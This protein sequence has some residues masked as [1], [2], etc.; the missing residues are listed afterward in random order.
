MSIFHRHSCS[1]ASK[2]DWDSIHAKV[3]KR[4]KARNPR[5]NVEDVMSAV[6]W[7]VATTHRLVEDGLQIDYLEKYVLVVASRTLSKDCKRSPERNFEF[8]EIE[9]E[10]LSGPFNATPEE[11]LVLRELHE[12]LA[13]A[14]ME[15]PKKLR[16]PLIARFLVGMSYAEMEKA[17]GVPEGTLRN[18]VY[19]GRKK[20]QAEIE[21]HGF[22][23][24]R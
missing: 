4:L 6:T 11:I 23:R 10:D 12:T 16:D 5:L 24:E 21:Q 8:S 17:M 3:F 13:H 9:I 18:D 15:L 20:L 14:I 19:K 7:A 2:N 22:C 1:P